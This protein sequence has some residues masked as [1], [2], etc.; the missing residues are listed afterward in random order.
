MLHITFTENRYSRILVLE[1]RNVEICIMKCTS[2]KQFKKL[3]YRVYKLKENA[4][5]ASG[6]EY[7]RIFCQAALLHHW[8]TAAFL[9]ALCHSLYFSLASPAFVWYTLHAFCIFVYS[10]LIFTGQFCRA[11]IRSLPPWMLL[12]Q[13]WGVFLAF[14]TMLCCTFY[15]LST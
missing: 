9:S 6:G 1:R 13:K 15:V 4:A 2:I 11:S 8:Y 12:E 10:F 5:F 14:P 3:K 7:F